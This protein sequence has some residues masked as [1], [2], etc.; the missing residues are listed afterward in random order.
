MY[1][2][3]SASNLF[4]A[5]FDKNSFQFVTNIQLV[6][7]ICE[8]FKFEINSVLDKKSNF[9][10]ESVITFINLCLET[11]RRGCFFKACDTLLVSKCY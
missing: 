3:F 9:F 2:I 7:K 8:K 6:T 1:C 10:S 4:S 11:L 5:K